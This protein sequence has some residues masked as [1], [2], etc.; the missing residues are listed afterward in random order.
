MKQGEGGKR[1]KRSSV[2]GQ[3]REQQKKRSSEAGQKTQNRQGEGGKKR[4]KKEGKRPSI[5]WSEGE[6][7]KERLPP[8]KGGNKGGEDYRTKGQNDPAKAGQRR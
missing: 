5:G 1:S 8:K 6:L 2:A 7:E 3:K 4:T